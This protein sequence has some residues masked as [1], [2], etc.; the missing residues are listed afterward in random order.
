MT[1]RI[2]DFVKNIIHGFL[3]TGVRLMKFASRLR[4]QLAK[5]I[6]VPQ[7]MKRVK[8][9][10]GAHVRSFSFNNDNF[11]DDPIVCPRPLGDGRLRSANLQFGPGSFGQAHSGQVQ[12]DLPELP[13]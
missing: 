8:Y 11:G 13:K 1:F 2:G 3:D 10:I 5:H 9:T 6:P 4:G 7:G 12:R